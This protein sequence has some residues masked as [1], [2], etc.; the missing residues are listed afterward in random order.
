[1]IPF[2]DF[3]NHSDWGVYDFVVSKQQDDTVKGDFEIIEK[4]KQ[5]YLILFKETMPSDE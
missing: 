2:I 5:M 1:M 4:W 3:F